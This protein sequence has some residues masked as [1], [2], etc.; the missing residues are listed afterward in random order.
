MHLSF[1]GFSLVNW[2][3]NQGISFDGSLSSAQATALFKMLG[4]E[5]FL[6]N[7]ACDRTE[8]P[9]SIKK[10]DQSGWSSGI[11]F[12]LIIDVML[13]KNKVLVSCKGVSQTACT[14]NLDSK[15]LYS[16][17]FHWVY[18]VGQHYSDDNRKRLMKYFI[19][20]QGILS[21]LTP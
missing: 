19:G 13:L 14:C 18:F 20:R 15:T 9:Y 16:K 4:I 1:K 7:P 5:S 11:L 10:I 2:M 6:K 21:F 17:C 3:K 8:S 12:K